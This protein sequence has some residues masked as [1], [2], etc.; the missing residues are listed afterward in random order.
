MNTP[1]RIKTRYRTEQPSGFTLL[2]VLL[3]VAI[4]LIGLTAMFHTAHSALLR[5]SIAKELT[6]AQNACQSVLNELLAQAAPIRPDTGKTMDRLPN[7]RIR[8]DIYPASQPDL[9]V[10][11]LSAQQFSPTDD[12]LIDTKYQLIRWVPA[13]RVQ[14]PDEQSMPFG[15]SGFESLFP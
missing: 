6:D 1:H 4:L 3:A 11:H 5:M 8:V 13:E 12:T 15:I 14:L 7:W 2:E 9:Y 10:L